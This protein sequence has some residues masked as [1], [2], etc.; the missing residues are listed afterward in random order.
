VT[1]IM[2]PEGAAMDD[3]LAGWDPDRRAALEK[4]WERFERAAGVASLGEE[5]IVD[6]RRQAAA[7]DAS[8]RE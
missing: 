2:S 5:L 1:L 3:A 6:R 4:V 8:A 7:E